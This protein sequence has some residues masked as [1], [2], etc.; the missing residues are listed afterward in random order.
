LI[1]GLHGGTISRTLTTK[2]NKRSNKILAQYRK[3]GMNNQKNCPGI[4]KK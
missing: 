2:K 1:L 3:A 4:T